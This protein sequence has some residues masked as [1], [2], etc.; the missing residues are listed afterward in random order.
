MDQH[1]RK[2]SRSHP[3]TLR[4]MDSPFYQDPVVRAHNPRKQQSST[5]TDCDWH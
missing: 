4:R 2:A 1:R 3:P 5:A